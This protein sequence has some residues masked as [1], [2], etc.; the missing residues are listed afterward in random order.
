M[1]HSFI[2]AH[3]DEREAFVNFA[4]ANPGNVTLLIDTYDTLQG[5]R[6]A[7]EVAGELR[8]T[9][10]MFGRCGSTAAISSG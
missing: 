8:S 10:S 2:E 6:T 3:E 5:A 7:V 1:A 4:L 9:A